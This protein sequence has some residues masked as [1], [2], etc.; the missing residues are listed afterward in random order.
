[1]GRMVIGMSEMKIVYRSL[2]EIH[3]YERNPRNTEPAVKAVAASIQAFG[4]LVPII[5]DSEENKTI[6]AG[7]TRYLAAQRL[8][9]SEVPTVLA[10]TLTPDQIRA[11]RLADNR[12]AEIAVWDLPLLD[13]AMD[14]IGDAFDMGE[15]GFDLGGGDVYDPKDTSKELDA[16]A[17]DDEAFDYQCP[18]CGFMFNEYE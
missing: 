15:F 14:D 10:D 6:V 7:H 9:L 16:G 17:F 5:L 11:Y 2:N 13:E 12:V 18:E 8:N 1:M 3:P 4:F